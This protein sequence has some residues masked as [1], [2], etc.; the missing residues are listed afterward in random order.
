MKQTASQNNLYMLHKIENIEKEVMDLKLS[1]FKN[2]SP[3][4]KKLISFKGII[5]D[6]D[7]TDEDIIIAKKSIYSKIRI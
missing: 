3:A 6:V 5:K 4:R 7:I 2:L 1:F